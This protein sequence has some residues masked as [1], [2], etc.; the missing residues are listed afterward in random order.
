[1]Q[2]PHTWQRTS[3]TIRCILL[4]IYKR[5]RIQLFFLSYIKKHNVQIAA[6]EVQRLLA[7]YNEQTS[8]RNIV[9]CNSKYKS[10]GHL[11][12]LNKHLKRT[13]STSFLF[14]SSPN[15]LL[16]YIPVLTFRTQKQYIYKHTR[17][18]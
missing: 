15:Q 14:R 16:Q 18:L 4:R 6:C 10:Q 13:C 1:M 5:I 2:S 12:N 3:Y 9:L 8:T 11:V 17:F 7:L